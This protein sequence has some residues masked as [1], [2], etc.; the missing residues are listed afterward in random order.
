MVI[1]T[2]PVCEPEDGK[3]LASKRESKGVSFVLETEHEPD[4]KKNN[5]QSFSSP[6][7]LINDAEFLA[8]P[9]KLPLSRSKTY[10]SSLNLNMKLERKKWSSS[11]FLKANA[12][13]HKVFKDIPHEETLQESFTCALQ[14]EILYHG[15]L[16]ISENWICFH[17]KVFGKDTKIVIP[18]LAVTLIKKTKTAILVPNALIIATIT[19]RFIFVSLLTRDSTYK[20]LKSVCSHLENLSTGNSPN[21]SPV[22][23]SFRGERS[24]T[25]DFNVDFPELDGLIARKDLEEYSSSGSQAT[26]SEHSQEFTE[27]EKSV[28]SKSQTSLDCVGGSAK[29][30]IETKNQVTEQRRGV[31][32]LFQTV[33][34]WQTISLNGLLILYAILVCLLFFSTLYMQ[35]R[36]G[37][38]EEK[39]SN[40]KPI[41]DS[42]AKEW[43]LEQGMSQW[44]KNA[45]SICDELTTNLEKLDK[46]QKNLQRLLEDVN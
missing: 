4:E 23:H 10:D 29:Q 27:P 34:I 15:K 5:R 26:E 28:F 33:D 1:M 24:A 44:N 41:R 17:S 40:L 2:E 46:I 8:D 32:G 9:R 20:L 14:K 16:Y 13:Y 35:S 12:Q 36:I 3:R 31:M 43:P 39:L 21:P 25:H 11:Q 6:Q 37:F 30:T 45:D 42:H 38:L 18:V 19:E 22:E 7:I